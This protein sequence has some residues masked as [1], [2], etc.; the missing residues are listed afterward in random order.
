[1][2]ATGPLSVLR[3]NGY[4]GTVATAGPRVLSRTGRVQ[5]RLTT[6]GS[7]RAFLV[8]T[9]TK[10]LYTERK[11]PLVYHTVAGATATVTNMLR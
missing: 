9:L 4:W 3:H 5:T 7:G 1:M 10:A 11:N 6:A 2:R 8:R